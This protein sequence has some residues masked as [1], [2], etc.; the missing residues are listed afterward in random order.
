M[1]TTLLLSMILTITTIVLY[2]IGVTV[3]IIYL[4]VNDNLPSLTMI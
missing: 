1:T 3:P 4:H 2:L